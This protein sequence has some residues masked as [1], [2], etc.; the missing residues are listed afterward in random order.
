MGSSHPASDRKLVKRA[1]AGQGQIPT[2]KAAPGRPGLVAP[3]APK[4]SG[5][6]P[7]QWEAAQAAY[8]LA[9]RDHFRAIAAFNRKRCVALG[10]STYEWLAVDVHK[11]CE[12]ARRNGG[13]VFSYDK[14]P[15]EG[16]VGEGECNSPDW[17]RFTA[18]PIVPGFS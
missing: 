1:T 10:I 9:M 14:P 6:S 2:V 13:K 15:P 5:K 16:H 7:E 18:R 8:R 4:K 17:C 3:A 11:T 12:V